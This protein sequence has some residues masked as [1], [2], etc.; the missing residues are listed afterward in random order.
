MEPC[1]RIIVSL[2]EVEANEMISLTNVLLKHVGFFKVG[3]ELISRILSNLFRFYSHEY[4]AY[5]YLY[6]IRRLGFLIGKNVFLDTNFN[7]TPEAV[8]KACKAVALME[9]AILTVNALAGKQVTEEVIA[10][11]GNSRVFGKAIFSSVMEREE[12]FSIFGA[13]H[14]F[15]IISCA[16]TL[17]KS[18]ADGIICSVDEAVILRECPEFDKLTIACSDI[19][20]SFDTLPSIRDGEK[21]ITPYDAILAGVDM[22]IIDG[23]IAN[24]LLGSGELVQ[25]VQKITREVSEALKAR[26]F[27]GGI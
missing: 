13:S 22:L 23:A 19:L 15:E 24:S 8:E 1:E 2:D 7:D 11:K 4:K 27:A 6:E 20:L 12:C 9:P 5:R 10:N 3:L 25:A 26:A 17:V 21:Q 18:G 14:E 16:R